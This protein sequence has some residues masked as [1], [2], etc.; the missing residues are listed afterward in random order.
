LKLKEI[1]SEPGFAVKCHSPSRPGLHGGRKALAPL[2]ITTPTLDADSFTF[3]SPPRLAHAHTVNAEILNAS[4][5]V[6]SVNLLQNN[7]RNPIIAKRNPNIDRMI[8]DNTKLATPKY[9]P[10]EK[11]KPAFGSFGLSRSASCTSTGG[12][13]TLKDI[14]SGSVGPHNWSNNTSAEDL[15]GVV[16]NTYTHNLVKQLQH[17]SSGVSGVSGVSRSTTNSSGSGSTDVSDY[18]VVTTSM[19]EVLIML[20]DNSPK[21]GKES[22]IY[23]EPRGVDVRQHQLLLFKSL[24][25]Y[26]GQEYKK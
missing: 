1:K 5:D 16:N 17:H 14:S 6:S 13:F 18:S 24:K 10:N 8:Q 21:G 20:N 3:L 12:S 15:T 19:E 2:I 11:L 25:E 4:I 7:P 22:P 9:S 23:P 26:V